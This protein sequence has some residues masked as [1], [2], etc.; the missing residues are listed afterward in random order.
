L[1]TAEDVKG[2]YWCLH[3][4]RAFH[5]D[6]VFEHEVTEAGMKPALCGYWEKDDCD[7]LLWDFWTWEDF[8][9]GRKVP[10]IPL[11]DVRYGLYET[12]DEEAA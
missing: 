12:M 11:R 4:E 9:K 5:S 1:K 3:C 8:S 7:G 6:D 2:W 10:V